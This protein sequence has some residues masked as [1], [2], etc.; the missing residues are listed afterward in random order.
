MVKIPE[1]LIGDTKRI[2][3]WKLFLDECGL[4]KVQLSSEELKKLLK[5][6]FLR[7]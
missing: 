6:L 2:I 4:S 3:Q 7:K 1:K 5:A